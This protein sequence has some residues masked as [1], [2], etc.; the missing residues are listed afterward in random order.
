MDFLVLVNYKID[1]IDMNKFYIGL[2]KSFNKFLIYRKQLEID[3]G[4]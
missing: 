4:G 3:S 1:C 2:A